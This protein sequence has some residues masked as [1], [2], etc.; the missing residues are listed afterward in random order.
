MYAMDSDQEFT[1]VFKRMTNAW[2]VIDSLRTATSLGMPYAAEIVKTQHMSFVSDLALSGQLEK[3]IVGIRD[4]ADLK[5]TADFLQDRL[6]EQTLRNATY[7]VD[8][9]SLVFA[10]TVLEDGVDS[11]VEITSQVAPD[12]WR[13]RVKGRQVTLESVLEQGPDS[14]LHSL[15]SKEIGGI[16][17]NESLLKKTDLLHAICRPPGEPDHPEYKFDA[18]KLEQIDKIRRDIIHGDFL[19]SEIADIDGKLAFLRN[20]WMYFFV[21]MHKSFGLRID[22]AAVTSAKH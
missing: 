1:I 16:C 12:F 21:M 5:K 17:R 3:L 15:I 11:F 22:P 19:G 8:A 20:T 14:C 18:E 10:H 2:A 4:A 13:A 6:T 9:A 7:S